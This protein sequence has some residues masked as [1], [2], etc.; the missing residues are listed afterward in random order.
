MTQGGVQMAKVKLQSTEF[1]AIKEFTDREDPQEAFERKFR[2]LSEN[3][4]EEYYVLCYYGKGGVG[5]TSFLDKLCRVIRGVEG[6][7]TRLLDKIECNY[8]RYD[9][10][11]KSSG[12]DKLTILL[13]LRR[14]L[15]EVD[16]NFKFFRFDSAVLLYAKKEWNQH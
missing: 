12:T 1:E 14:Q 2:V 3:W 6:N 8:I 16:K 9:F 7:A 4:K 11:A 10:D 13:S 15:G 5:K